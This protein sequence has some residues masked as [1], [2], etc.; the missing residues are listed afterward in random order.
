MI[1]QLGEASCII[2]TVGSNPR[3]PKRERAAF[4]I[5]NHVTTYRELLLISNY[6][7]RLHVDRYHMESIINTSDEV[8]RYDR[9]P[10]LIARR[11][12]K[13]G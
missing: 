4:F 1:V 13:I 2:G 6:S 3:R 12:K 11:A 7:R 9:V 5:H 10:S 8:A